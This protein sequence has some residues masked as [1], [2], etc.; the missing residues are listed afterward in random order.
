MFLNNVSNLTCVAGSKLVFPS[1]ALKFTCIFYLNS[2]FQVA[3]VSK[4]YFKV[5]FVSKLYFLAAFASKLYFQVTFVSKV[6]FQ[7]RFYRLVSRGGL[8]KLYQHVILP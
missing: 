4:L 8:S 1:K 3:F 6:C 7:V 2:C 5:T